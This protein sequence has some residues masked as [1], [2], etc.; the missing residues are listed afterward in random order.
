MDPESVLVEP[1]TLFATLIVPRWHDR[2]GFIVYLFVCLV[3]AGICCLT[4][5]VSEVPVAETTIPVEICS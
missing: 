1:R 2:H 3:F 5:S 4:D